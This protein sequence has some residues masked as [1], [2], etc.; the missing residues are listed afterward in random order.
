MQFN[1]DIIIGYYLLVNRCVV[2]GLCDMCYYGDI[3]YLGVWCGVEYYVVMDF[4]VVKEIMEVRLFFFVVFVGNYYFWWDSLL[5]QF[6]VYIN[7]DMYIFFGNNIWCD[8]GFKWCIVVLM[9]YYFLI[10]DL[11]FV[12]MS[13]CIEMQYDMLVCLIFWYKDFVLILDVVYIIMNICIGELIVK[14]V[15]YSNCL[16]F[17]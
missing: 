7:G 13:D 15:W 1:V 12:V 4:G 17:L 3:V 8:I 6:V 16:V 9:F 2:I 14:I 10:I 5:V 11:Y